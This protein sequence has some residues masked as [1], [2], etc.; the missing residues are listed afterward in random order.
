MIFREATRADV[1]DVVRL[2]ADDFLGST[3]EHSDLKRY[4]AAFDQMQMEGQNHLIVGE[5]SDGTIVATYQIT[6]ISGLSLSA[7]RR[8]QIEAVRVD[9]TRRSEG[10]G[11]LLLADA[12]ARARAAGC[13]LVQL[14]MNTSRTDSCRFYTDH[15]FVASHTGFKKP[16]D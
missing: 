16:L 15:G 4:L 13:R 1:S 10:L 11:G 7:T 5:D 2:L 3:R 8:A 14:T 6:F 9:S 12:E